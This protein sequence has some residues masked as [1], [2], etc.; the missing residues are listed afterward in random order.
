MYHT[1]TLSIYV[2]YYCFQKKKNI[3]LPASGGSFHLNLLHTGLNN[4]AKYVPFLLI[5]LYENLH[6]W[7]EIKAGYFTITYL[8]QT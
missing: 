7:R 6:L 8:H 3:F 4:R 1:A 2:Q 5:Y